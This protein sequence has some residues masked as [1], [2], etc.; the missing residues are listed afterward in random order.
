MSHFLRWNRQAY[1]MTPESGT[2]E[3]PESRCLYT[4]ALRQGV[5]I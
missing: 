2:P 3:S 1:S 4:N 5:H